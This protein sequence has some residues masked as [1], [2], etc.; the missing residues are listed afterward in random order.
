MQKRF[1]LSKYGQY[2]KDIFEKLNFNFEPGK[3]ILDVG[4]GDGSDMEIFINEYNLNSYGI[5]IYKHKN[6]DKLGINFNKAGILNIPFDN[7]DFDYVFLHDVLH[8]I[9]E[10]HQN[11]EKHIRGLQELKRV[12]RKGGYI[13]ILEANRYNI[14][15]YPHM[16]L[17]R[18][19]NHFTQI[20]FKKILKDIFG[21]NINFRS[22]EAHLYPSKLLKL[23]KIYEFFM[24]HIKIL[25]A[26]RDYNLAIIKNDK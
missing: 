26:F 14:L 18:R 5:D 12:C 15:S 1:N 7:E 4:C 11:C 24:E 10:E 25:A 16:V 2:K 13:I 23:F 8:H 21:E 19:H 9:D 17:M 22:F 3:K 6:I 20:Y